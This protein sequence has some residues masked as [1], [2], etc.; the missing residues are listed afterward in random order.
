MF[1]YRAAVD[2]GI[3]RHFTKNQSKLI[4]LILPSFFATAVRT[5][6]QYM[7][8]TL[9]QVSYPALLCLCLSRPEQNPVFNTARMHLNKSVFPRVQERETTFHRHTRPQIYTYIY[10]TCTHTHCFDMF[11]NPLILSHNRTKT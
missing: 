10:Y 11:A 7:G 2:V 4:G 9:N 6:P 1:A 3:Q 8:C 5:Q